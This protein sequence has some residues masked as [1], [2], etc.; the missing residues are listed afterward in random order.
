MEQKALEGTEGPIQCEEC[1]A[2][3]HWTIL[4]F[5][6]GAD[7]LRLCKICHL[8]HTRKAGNTLFVVMVLVWLAIVWAA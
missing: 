1:G 6:D 2:F 4:V 3:V 5:L 8:K 7:P